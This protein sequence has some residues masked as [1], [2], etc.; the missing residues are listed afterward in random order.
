MT[1]YRWDARDYAQSSSAQQRWALELLD[2][3]TLRGDER[4]LDVGCG[5]GKVTAEIAARRPEG[6]VVGVDNSSDMISLAQSSYPPESHPNLR[7][8]WGDATSL[9]FCDQF[10]TAF[11]NATLHWIR[12]HRPVLAGIARSLQRGG[13]AL[14]QMGG[15]GNAADLLAV[16]D[17]L[18]ATHEWRGYFEGMPFPYGFNGPDEYRHWLPEAGLEARRLELIP[19][20]MTHAGRAGFDGWVRTTWMP[21]TQR[22][23][24]ERREDFLAQVLDAYLARHP[25]DALGRVHIAMVRLEVEARKP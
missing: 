13:V 16:L 10:T 5:D 11:S 7:F 25:A 2:K 15:R 18:C 6:S 12:D 22:V 4:L 1:V 21:F 20:D 8:Q 14:L 9:P 24:P 19:K 23:P 3:L 17:T